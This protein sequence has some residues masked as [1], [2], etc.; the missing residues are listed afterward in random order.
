MNA[1]SLHADCLISISRSVSFFT[2]NAT[3]AL[4]IAIKSLA[5][6]ETRV[7]ISGYEH[8]SVTQSLHDI[9][10]DVSVA[11]GELFDPDSVLAAFEEKIP[12]ADLCRLQPCLKCFR[13]LFS[14]CMR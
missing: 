3:H 8:N 1:G 9:S 4:N 6:R 2:L 12:G 14:R 10:A 13:F 7:V 5:R 11:A